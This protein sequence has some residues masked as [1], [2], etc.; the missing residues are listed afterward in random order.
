[1]SEV[2]QADVLGIANDQGTSALNKLRMLG[3]E[4]LETVQASLTPK[5][6]GLIGL[7]LESASIPSENSARRS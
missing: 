7:A 4:G 3:K 5:T 2:V 1:L 6:T